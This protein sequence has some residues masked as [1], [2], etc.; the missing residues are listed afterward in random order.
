MEESRV[1]G[2]VLDVAGRRRQMEGNWAEIRIIN[3]KQDDSRDSS[4][5]L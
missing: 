2:G 3:T 5:S 4:F 1:W